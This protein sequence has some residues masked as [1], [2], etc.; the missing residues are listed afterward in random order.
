M[1]STLLLA[2]AAGV[3]SHSNLVAVQGEVDNDLCSVYVL[4]GTYHQDGILAFTHV[5]PEGA[6]SL[7]AKPL[8]G[9]SEYTCDPSATDECTVEVYGSGGAE[10]DQTNPMVETFDAPAAGIDWD[11]SGHTDGG[12]FSG[13]ATSWT[14]SELSAAGWVITSDMTAGDIYNFQQVQ[15]DGVA[16]GSYLLR[17]DTDPVGATAADALSDNYAA[18]DA[19]CCSGCAGFRME[20]VVM[21][22][23]NNCGVSVSGTYVGETV[24]DPSPSPP[25]ASPSPP[26]PTVGFSE[27]LWTR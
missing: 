19:S 3:A 17:Y 22:V 24:T 11:A 23:T 10:S 25:A 1:R 20:T 8:G 12:F 13:G 16:S 18:C 5:N 7:Y 26:P 9:A 15:I 2:A 21:Q 6:M 4:I 14:I 27:W